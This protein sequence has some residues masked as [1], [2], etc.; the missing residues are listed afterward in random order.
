M[1]EQAPTYTKGSLYQIPCADLQTDPNQPR[2]YF[3]PEALQDLV[4][5]IKDKGVLQPILF[6]VDQDG[7]SGV[8][9]VEH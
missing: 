8:S 9:D 5:S 3:D 7:V 4:D 2:T 1:V 6:R